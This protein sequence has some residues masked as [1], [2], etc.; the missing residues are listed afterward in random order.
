MSDVYLQTILIIA[1]AV[2]T[3]LLVTLLV[4]R[5]HH[6]GPAPAKESEGSRS[7]QA[8]LP[9]DEV[10]HLTE[11]DLEKLRA[12]AKEAFGEAVDEG[13]KIFHN[14]LA[15]TSE[16]L[17]KLVVRIT[18][19]VVE[20]ELDEYRQGLSTARSAALASLQQM[21]SSVEQ[22]QRDLEA[23]VDSEM[24]KRRQFLMERLDKK[25]G[26]AV[27]AYIVESLGM[28]ADLGAQRA[29]LLENLERH[30]KELKAEIVDGGSTK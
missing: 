9:A 7:G 29:F 16:Q 10:P 17:N 23:D 1:L 20:R 14:D 4:V 24:Q 27:S 11:D 6:R 30:K 28:D 15:S 22:K 26:A 13:A 21:Q 2:E 25:L 18:T 8:A 12:K 19:D 5:G 3:V